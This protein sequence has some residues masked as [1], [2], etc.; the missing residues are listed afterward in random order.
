MRVHLMMTMSGT[1]PLAH[2][3]SH[4]YTHAR[5]AFFLISLFFLFPHFFFPL[6]LFPYTA[7]GGAVR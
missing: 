5:H 2:N 4:V 7:G 1:R 6:L 3:Q